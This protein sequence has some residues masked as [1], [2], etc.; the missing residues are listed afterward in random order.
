MRNR[1]F[2]MDE[3]DLDVFRKVCTALYLITVYSLSGVLFYRQFV[4]HQSISEWNDIAMIV[5]IN[6]FACLGA[7]LYISGGVRLKN[8]KLGHIIAGFTGFVVLGIAFTLFKYGILLGQDLNW[9][10]I[11][12]MFY[13]VVRISALI[14]LGLGVLA[15]LGNRR[16][17]KQI[18]G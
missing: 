6:I 2:K 3:R 5:T 12:G 14:A 8:I 1:P 4:L 13:L 11:W 15:Y 7:L 18:E 10:E 16:I 17:E 9:G